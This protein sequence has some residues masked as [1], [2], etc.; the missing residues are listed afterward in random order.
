MKKK[1]TAFAFMVLRM[2]ERKTPN[3]GTTI[4]G[5]MQDSRIMT[6]IMIDDKLWR[7]NLYQLNVKE[8]MIKSKDS[9][10]AVIE[11]SGN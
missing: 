9:E 3:E 5:K 11:L 2:C 10:R 4:N 7:S 6:C 8:K 1:K